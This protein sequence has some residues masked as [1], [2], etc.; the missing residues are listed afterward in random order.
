MA[1]VEFYAYLF[2][3]T[4]TEDVCI[5][6]SLYRFSHANCKKC[7]VSLLERIGK[8]YK[9]DRRHSKFITDLM[10]LDTPNVLLVQSVGK[11]I[12]K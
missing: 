11:M 7:I 8:A 4:N 6:I 1:V 10:K 9:S 2:F 3:A 12:P 5:N